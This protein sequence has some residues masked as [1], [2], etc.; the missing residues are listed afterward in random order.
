ML[1]PLC[2]RE[3]VPPCRTKSRARPGGR[4]TSNFPKLAAP[5]DSNSNMSVTR[6]SPSPFGRARKLAVVRL[7]KASSDWRPGIPGCLTYPDRAAAHAV[8]RFTVRVNR[9]LAAVVML[10][11][12]GSMG[13]CQSHDSTPRSV[14][15]FLRAYFAKPALDDSIQDAVKTGDVARVRERLEKEPQLVALRDHTGVTL[16]HL[17]AWW[18][19]ADVAKLL[20]EKGADKEA[21]DGGG[22]TPLLWAARW[23][24]RDVVE[25]LLTH[26]ASP[27]SSVQ[28][29]YT[30]LH[31][32]AQYGHLEISEL[33]LAHGAD[34]N[35]RNINGNMPLHLAASWN[36]AEVAELLLSKGADANARGAHD[37]TPLHSAFWHVGGQRTSAL[38]LV[39]TL[40]NHKGDANARD[41]GGN[42]PLF[43]AA[44][45]GDVE[46]VE[47]LLA[48]GAD[49]HATNNDG[50][51]PLQTGLV[52]P[53]VSSIR[54]THPEVVERLIRAGADVNK[55][56]RSG[57]AP[58]HVA[59]V[60]GGVNMARVLL[61]N[62]ARLELRTR[63]DA[64]ALHLAAR[65]GHSAV[66]ELLLA[67]GADVNVREGGS[68]TPL[69]WAVSQGHPQ[70]AQ[71]LVRAGADVNAKD[72]AGE[73]PLRLTWGGSDSDKAIRR[74]LRDH[75]AQEDR[76][77]KGW[78]D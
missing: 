72:R 48:R 21:K 54:D 1:E 9:F 71:V 39:E 19:Q 31:L 34:L 28:G 27:K 5:M 61:A 29:D 7:R 76:V 70:V 46:A 17:A 35:A 64:T 3:L 4:R 30:P 57:L 24:Q 25:L 18:G 74:L 50:R 44:L 68:R 14:H 52:I 32:A 43:Y 22:N 66:V 60:E 65:H 45:N 56:D 73:T 63:E 23:G 78:Q 13:G 62:G 58:L 8:L 55:L 12:A 40:L 53:Q 47:I 49:V 38:K 2:G 51:S 15:E 26:G 10:V 41:G 33:L 11:A 77:T 67:S 20:L 6:T 59:A 16:L 69:H 36:R 42:S 37:T 75:G